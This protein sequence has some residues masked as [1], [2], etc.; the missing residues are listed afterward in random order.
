M[1]YD[2]Q[3]Q[4]KHM[5]RQS[6]EEAA[7]TLVPAPPCAR[8]VVERRSAN[9]VDQRGPRRGERPTSGAKSS[10]TV[11]RDAPSGVWGRSERG[12]GSACSRMPRVLLEWEDGGSGGAKATGNALRRRERPHGTAGISC[13]VMSPTLC[14]R[15]PP[16]PATYRAG[17]AVLNRTLPRSSTSTG[18]WHTCQ[19]QL[20]ACDVRT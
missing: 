12:V 14:P 18:S 6:E 1:T 9:I 17:V 15:H 11:P 2:C 7:R 10:G 16:C 3:W 19:R 13:Y 20:Q 4:S 5:G 8:A